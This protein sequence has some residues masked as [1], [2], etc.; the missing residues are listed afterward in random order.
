MIQ[1]K[2]NVKMKF[3]A[4]FCQNHLG[5]RK[6]LEKQIIVAKENGAT[7]G[8][9][10]GLYSWELVRREEFEASTDKSV[11]RNQITRPYSDEYSRLKKLDLTFDDEKWFIE[12]CKDNDLIPMITV[13]THTGAKRAED[14]GFKHIKIA[15][16]DCESIPLIAT[17]LKFAETLVI[18][19]GAS[20][21]QGVSKTAQFLHQTKSLK[22]EISFL[23]ATTLYPTKIEQSSIFRM[24]ALRVFGFDIGFSDHSSPSDSQLFASKLAIFFGA[25]YIERHFTVLEK[26]ETRDGPVSINGTELS[27]LIDFSNLKQ[28]EQC[29]YFM[30][31]YCDKY[32]QAISTLNIEPVA[33]EMNNRQYYRGRVAAH[34]DGKPIFSWEENG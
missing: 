13:F 34:V 23:H 30:E 7:F 3:I 4:E 26:N 21:W 31:N 19:T 5:D 10:Q 8:K 17:V 24:L 16:Y 27:E 28:S 12:I 25:K 11:N 1:F 33:A 2:K 22:K 14:A 32:Y 18:S 29:E 9:I 15:S 20:S 6:I